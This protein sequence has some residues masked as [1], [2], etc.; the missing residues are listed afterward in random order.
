MQ[1]TLSTLKSKL[2]YKLLSERTVFS[3]IFHLEEGRIQ[4]TDEAGKPHKEFSRLRLNRQNA[5]AVFIYN[6]ETKKVV[7]VRQFRYAIAAK[8]PEPI[9]EIMAGRISVGEDPLETALRE[10]I[11]E[12]GYRI[13]KENIQLLS[14]FFASPG[15]SSE[16]FFLYYATVTNA[17]KVAL[18]GGLEDEDEYIEVVEMTYPDFFK[19]LDENKIEDAKTLMAGLYVR[20]NVSFSR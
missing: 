11:E 19:L 9:L 16:K 13:R 18:G 3:D 5:S 10:S 4:Y 17:D 2:M 15:Y 1:N 7:L 6:Q 20:A 14:S 12:C 8:S